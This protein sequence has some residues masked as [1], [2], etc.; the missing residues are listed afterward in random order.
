MCSLKYALDFTLLVV[1]IILGYTVLASSLHWLLLVML[2]V[3]GLLL[4][5]ATFE[6]CWLYR[7][8]LPLTQV[9]IIPSSRQ[10]IETIADM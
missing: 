1:P 5:L 8:K 6:Y 3:C 9:C 4:T 10:F 2:L 7:D